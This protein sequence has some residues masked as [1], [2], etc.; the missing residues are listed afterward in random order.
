M[1]RGGIAFL[2]RWTLGAF[3][4]LTIRLPDFGLACPRERI[5]RRERITPF[6]ELLLLQAR[7]CGA[8]GARGMRFMRQVPV[9]ENCVEH[10]G[11]RA[12]RFAAVNGVVAKQ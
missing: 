2:R 6:L 8:S 3:S 1:R 4:A 10:Q 9:T 12:N 7:R 11:V 5:W